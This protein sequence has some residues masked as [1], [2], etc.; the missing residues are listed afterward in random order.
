MNQ[1]L[2]E[3]SYRTKMLLV[4]AILFSLLTV[5]REAVR[6]VTA[7][8]MLP[9]DSAYL[10][11]AREPLGLDV[12]FSVLLVVAVFVWLYYVFG[13]CEL[14]S[15]GFGILAGY[16]VLNF[17]LGFTSRAY[18][19]IFIGSPV[20]SFHFHYSFEIWCVLP[21]L[22]RAL[23]SVVLFLTV[24]GYQRENAFLLKNGKILCYA[25]AVLCALSSI[26]GRVV[27]DSYNWERS[28]YYDSEFFV[29]DIDTLIFNSLLFVA[30]LLMGVYV[31]LRLR[32]A[33][34]VKEEVLAEE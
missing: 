30:F 5:I 22:L 1:C 20:Y 11:Y 2:S 7:L 12:G 10:N 4:T 24:W 32:A 9:E 6:R 28:D 25:P 21:M 18:G 13:R 34:G 19:E 3:R 33:G 16:D 8:W 31:H 14:L 27:S 15:V 29:Y 23:A 17:L 26:V